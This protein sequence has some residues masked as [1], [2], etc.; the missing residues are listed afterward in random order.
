VG[1]G[2]AARVHV[3]AYRECD[4]VVAVVS[5]DNDPVK[6]ARAQ[7]DLDVPGYSSLQKKLR[8]EVPDAVC[9]LTP[10]ASHEDRSYGSPL[11]RARVVRWRHA[12]E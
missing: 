7:R 3:N 5:A 10:P 4:P 2:E 8:A 1:I 9:L 6:L 12:R 11:K